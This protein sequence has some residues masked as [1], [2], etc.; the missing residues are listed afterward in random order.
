MEQDLAHYDRLSSDSPDKSY[1]DLLRCCRRV[2]ERNRLAWARIELSRS[3]EQGG[4]AFVTTGK[5]KEAQRT[6]SQ[7][8]LLRPCARDDDSDAQV[9]ESVENQS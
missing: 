5:G 2:T 3:I 4:R 7:L 9:L 1:G 6:N 8:L